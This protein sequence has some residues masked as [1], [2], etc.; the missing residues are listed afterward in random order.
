MRNG[1]H[2][3]NRSTLWAGSPTATPIPHNS[4]MESSASYEERSY[5]PQRLEGVHLRSRKSDASEDP[6]DR[7]KFIISIQPELTST[8]G[9]VFLSPSLEHVSAA[10]ET[11]GGTECFSALDGSYRLLW[12]N[13]QV[14]PS[15]PKSQEASSL[16]MLRAIAGSF[17]GPGSGRLIATMSQDNPRIPLSS[18]ST[19]CLASITWIKTQQAT[20]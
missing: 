9:S 11:T 2:S 8:C 6:V 17:L 1:G 15:R 7:A 5:R 3:Q 13:R 20:T 12:C 14:H 16:P 19:I 10:P 4:Q 18:R